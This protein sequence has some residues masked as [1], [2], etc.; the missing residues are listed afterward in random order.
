MRGWESATKRVAERID[1]KGFVEMPLG[2]T[3]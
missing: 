3:P 2:L 1:L